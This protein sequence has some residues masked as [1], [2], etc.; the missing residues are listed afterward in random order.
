VDDPAMTMATTI[1]RSTRAL[2]LMAAFG[3]G[4]VGCSGAALSSPHDAGSGPWS[5]GGI[6]TRIEGGSFTP[7]DGGSFTP[8]DGEII[9]TLIGC[10]DELS[11]T[12]T[13]D[14][15][16]VPAGTHTVNV[17]ADGALMTCTFPFPTTNPALLSGAVAQCSSGL[18]LVVRPA[19][20]CTTTYTEAGSSDQCQTTD[21][22]WTESMTITGMP[23]VVHLQQLV[24]GTVI[25]DQTI[26]PRY[27][28][29]QPNQ[30]CG[31]ICHQASAAWTIP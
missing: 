27:Q 29:N 22:K 24:G 7:I 9:C 16:M 11:A 20:D 13:V 8:I 25:L 14:A 18:M 30:G 15:T 31:P 26:S 6:G 28:T 4:A 3:F 2:L 21:G 23:S 12:V 5:D 10:E 17:M 1:V 19:M